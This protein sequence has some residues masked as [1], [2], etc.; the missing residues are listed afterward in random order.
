MTTAKVGDRVVVQAAHLDQAVRDGEIVEVHGP[1]GEP[2]YLVRWS[3]DGH[4]SLFFPGP[5]ARVHRHEGGE[6]APEAVTG[7]G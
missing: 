2:P 3:A 4:T 5:D 6:A 1:G 7:P